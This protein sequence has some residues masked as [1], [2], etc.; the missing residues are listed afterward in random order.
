M[1]DVNPLGPLM[2]LKKIEREALALRAA[3]AES[4]SRVLKSALMWVVKL[5]TRLSISPQK[6]TAGDGANTVGNWRTI[7]PK[8]ETN[9]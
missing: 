4:R 2:H 3:R 1:F 9:P 6:M 8:G 5:R 7:G